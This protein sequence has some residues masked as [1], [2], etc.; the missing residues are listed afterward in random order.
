MNL[1]EPRD[2]AQLLSKEN[3]ELLTVIVES[4]PRNISELA[5]ALDRDYERVHQ[6]L[7][8]LNTLGVVE[9]DDTST[10]TRPILRGG[11]DSVHIDISI[12]GDN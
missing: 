2:I 12:K 8:E 11:A 9:F 7:N 3:I 4:T 5:S 1:H 6:G 10:N